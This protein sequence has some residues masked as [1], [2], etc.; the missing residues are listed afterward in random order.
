[1]RFVKWMGLVSVGLTSISAMAANSAVPLKDLDSATVV[2]L[3]QLSYSRLPVHKNISCWTTYQKGKVVFTDCSDSQGF[4][5]LSKTIDYGWNKSSSS[6]TL[7]VEE[8]NERVENDVGMFRMLVGSFF[9]SD[10][11]LDAGRGLVLNVG[12]TEVAQDAV[13]L[14]ATASDGKKL[15]IKCL[16]PNAT[17]ADIDFDLFGIITLRDIKA[18]APEVTPEPSTTPS[19]VPTDEPSGVPSPDQSSQ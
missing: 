15:Y 6:C 3:A 9:E 11:K 8:P 19:G 16:D 4:Q 17:T 18:K 2:T 12:D 13:L 5:R 1:M 10:I 7:V 14:K